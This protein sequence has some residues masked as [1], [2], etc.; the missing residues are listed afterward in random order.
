[1]SRGLAGTKSAARPLNASSDANVLGR[2]LRV[3]GR[4]TGEGDLRIEG[5]LEGDVKLAGVLELG[6]SATMSGNVTA[7]GV[8]VEGTLTGDVDADGPVHIKAGA[9]VSG[10]LSGT[11]IALDEGASFSGR[12]DADFELPDGLLAGGAT[13]QGVGGRRGK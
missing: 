2:S 3:R 12:I 13:A 6:G 1:M 11:E 7:R 10:N 9:R 8:L 4:L 5:D